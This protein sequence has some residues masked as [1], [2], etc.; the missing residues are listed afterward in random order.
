MIGMK[1]KHTEKKERERISNSKILRQKFNLSIR[2]E[3]FFL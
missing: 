2:I 1:H 3:H